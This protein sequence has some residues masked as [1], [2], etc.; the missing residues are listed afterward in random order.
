MERCEYSLLGDHSPSAAM[1]SIAVDVVV[2]PLGDQFRSGQVLV[3]ELREYHVVEV[4]W[5]ETPGSPVFVFF[6]SDRLSQTIW[7]IPGHCVSFPVASLPSS[8]VITC[9]RCQQLILRKS[10][11][12]VYCVFYVE[13]H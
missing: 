4:A 13:L 5:Q 7:H 3:W 10:F 2:E 1:K 9:S 12:Q 6:G 8:G 11:A